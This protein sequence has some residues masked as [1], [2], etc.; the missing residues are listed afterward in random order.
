MTPRLHLLFLLPICLQAADFTSTWNSTTGNWT[1]TTKWS[2]PGASGTFPNN[3]TSTYDAIMNGGTLFRDLAITIERFTL[4]GGSVQGANSLTLN[5]TFAFTAGAVDS[6]APVNANGGVT[7]N[8]ASDKFLGGNAVMNL[9]SDTAWSAGQLRYYGGTLNNAVTKTLTMSF[10]G[11]M[12]NNANT[13]NFN[14]AGIFTKSAGAGTATIGIAINNTG[15]VNANFGTLSLNGGGTSTGTWNVAGGATLGFGGG[16]HNLNSGSS[17][18]GTGVVAFTADTTSVNAGSTYN[19]A[20]TTVMSGGNAIFNTATT[21]HGLTMSGG[22][23]SG[24]GTVTVTGALNFTG[25]AMDGTGITNA[26]GGTTFSGGADK[27]IG[28]GRTLNLNSNSS[29]TGGPLRFWGGTLNNTASNTFTTSFDGT[30]QND[31]GT[32]TVNNAGIFTKSSGTGTTTIGIAFHNTGTVN[33]NYGTLSVNNGGTSTGVWNVTSGATLNFGSGTYSLNN[34]SSI[35]GTGTGVISFS[36][37]PHTVNA[38]T[39]YSVAGTTLINGSFVAF[40]NTATTN[41]LGVSSGRLQGTGTMTVTGTLNWTGGGFDNAGVTNANGGTTINTGNDKLIGT[42]RTLNFNSNSSWT[43]GLLRF[44]G[45]TFNNTAGNTFTTNFD[46]TVQNDTGTNIFNNAG[47]FTKSGG[48]GSTTLG[49][50]FTNTGTVNANSGTL[51]FNVS[52]TQTAGALVLNGGGVNRNGGNF[53]ITGGKIQGGG[54]ISGGVVGTGGSVHVEPGIGTVSTGILA[55]TGDLTLTASSKLA[56]HLK[57]ATPGTGH[58][59]LTEG[60]GTALNLNGSTLEF[61]VPG[62]FFPASGDSFIVVDSHAT[63]TGVFSNVA[64]GA[65]LSSPDGGVSCQVNYG[66]SSAFADKTQI[67]LSHFQSAPTTLLLDDN[68]VAE[69]SPAG[70]SIG[71]FSATDGNPN[72]TFSYSLVS[73]TGSTGNAQFQIV[74]NQLRTSAMFNYEAQTSYSIRVRVTNGIGATLEQ[75]FSIQVEDQGVSSLSLSPAS[76]LELQPA[77]TTVGGASSTVTPVGSAVTYTLVSGAGSTHNTQFAMDGSTLKTAA[78]LDYN[79][80]TTRSIRLRATD[81]NGETREQV[82]VI[83]IILINDP[84]TIGLISNRTVAEDAPQQTFLI[85]GLTSGSA[86]EV[87]A[88]TVTATSSHPSLIPHP[89]ITYTSPNA[90]GSLSFTPQPYTHGTATITVTV[91]DD[92]GTANGGIESFSRTFTIT[93]TPDPARDLNNRLQITPFGT[94]VRLT[95]AGLSGRTYGLLRTTDFVNW[96]QIAT[97][98]AA[99]VTGHLLHDDPNPPAPRAYYKII[100]PPQ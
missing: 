62:P 86:A 12:V 10:D 19:V 52:Y 56:F 94:G 47:F 61:V 85:G 68:R 29:W 25:R 36:S 18:N 49:I 28:T 82:F 21:T 73:G 14:N 60:G 63:I 34:G 58:D 43:G 97:P 39:S 72:E 24:T 95:L 13:N 32:N 45:A 48:T 38:G 6:S 88:L 84:P 22:N 64:N 1:D 41:S 27:F 37:G 83:S 71:L 79:L 66:A 3:G 55:I 54:T 70:T 23:L 89:G 77:G 35:N 53:T 90:T 93:V 2:T 69:N 75:V 33:A 9:N 40:N 65:R 42:G 81:A 96:T 76:I 92:G 50:A 44:W 78:V 87:Q 4:G 67:I 16:T 46:G 11:T 30:M 59:Q 99:A 15:T 8:T 26:N 80:G 57:G 7:I 5:S 17:V 91:T 98:T 74:G 51:Q 31:A 20:G 100:A